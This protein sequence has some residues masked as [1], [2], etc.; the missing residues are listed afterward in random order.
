MNK[1][2][3]EQCGKVH[4]FEKGKDCYYDT[5]CWD[6]KRYQ[7]MEID[8]YTCRLCSAPGQCVHHSNYS[9]GFGNEIVGL[10][11]ITLCYECHVDDVTCGQRRRRYAK[12][13]VAADVYIARDSVCPFKKESENDGRENQQEKDECVA[14]SPH[15]CERPDPPQWAIKRPIE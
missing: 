8:K 15:R 6:N 2:R 1:I 4:Q 13:P 11:L 12:R 10:D 9:R 14:L 7:Q 3:C 5:V